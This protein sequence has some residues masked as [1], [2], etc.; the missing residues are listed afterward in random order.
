MACVP[1]ES[2]G[3]EWCV[4]QPAIDAGGVAYANSEDGSLYAIGPDGSQR[5]S[6]FLNLALGAAYTPVSIGPDG[7]IYAQNDGHL[8]VVGHPS[9]PRT[10]PEFGSVAP[11][12]P[13]RT[14][15]R[16]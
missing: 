8:L 3:F 7:R 4:N 2:P 6:I 11:P 12:P 13:P 14:V 1:A 5:E 10:R 15:E 16:P 9:A